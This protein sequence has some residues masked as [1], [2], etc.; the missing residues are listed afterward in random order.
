MRTPSPP[1]SPPRGERIKVRGLTLTALLGVLLLLASPAL[2]ARA[3][4]VTTKE[5][6]GAPDKWHGRSVVLSGAVAHLEPRV[7]GR[8][9]AYFTFQ[10]VD[11]T[12][13]VRV[14]SYGTPEVRDGQRV[15][16]E[17]IFHKI[18]RVGTHTFENQVDA[19]RIR[20]R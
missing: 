16:V 20:P 9:N 4:Y 12:G 6:L 14:F 11:G 15:Q 7:S 19:R 2:A 18:K 8:G 10:L 13:V 17:G 3:D 5:L 1:P